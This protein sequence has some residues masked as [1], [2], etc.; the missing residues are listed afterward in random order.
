MLFSSISTRLATAMASAPPEP[1]S[2]MTTLTTGTVKPAHHLEVDRDGL[3]LPAL[4]GADARVGARGVHEGEHRAPEAV[5]QLHQAARLAVALGPRHP[6]VADHVLLGVP[7]L[8][9]AEQHHRP[10]VQPRPAPD[11]RRVLAEGA[12]A[13][14]LEEVGEEQLD[15][16]Q[17]VGPLGMPRELRHL[18]A[19]QVAEDLRLEPPGL[20][21]Q[22][23]DLGAE[24]ARGRES[25]FSSSIFRSRSSSG[26][27]K[28]RA[29]AGPATLSAPTGV[30]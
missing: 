18:P 15:V 11:D 28:S 27:S 20:L 26:R 10:A 17:E 2:P 25:A 19:R 22:L 12:V 16:V 6:E 13:G 1:P 4:L 3:R 21:L 14:E 7:A 24:V 30:W 5:G 23:L 8:L 9:V 29:N